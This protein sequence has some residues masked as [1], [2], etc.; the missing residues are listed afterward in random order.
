MLIKRRLNH[1]ISQFDDL[2]RLDRLSLDDTNKQDLTVGVSILLLF[3]GRGKELS[4]LTKIKA[5]LNFKYVK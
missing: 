5:P 4:F 1:D 2:D 3:K